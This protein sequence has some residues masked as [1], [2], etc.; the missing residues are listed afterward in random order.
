[1]ECKGD[2]KG[3]ICFVCILIIINIITGSMASRERDQRLEQKIDSISIKLD[4]IQSQLSSIKVK[5]YGE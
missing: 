3:Y 2:N 5:T 1:M 4:S